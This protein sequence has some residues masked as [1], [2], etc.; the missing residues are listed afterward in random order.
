MKPLIAFTLGLLPFAALAAPAPVV[1]PPP[2][3]E[4][5]YTLISSTSISATGKN[6]PNPFNEG[7]G[8]GSFGPSGSR[9]ETVITKDSIAID[10]RT[11]N[12][13]Y[14]IDPTTKPMS[15]DITITPLRGKKSKVLGIIETVGDKLTIAYAADGAERP[16]DF[17]DAEGISHFVFQ[18]APPPP[19]LEYKIVVLKGGKEQDAEK[20]LNALAKD[21]Y[22]VMS[23]HATPTPGDPTIHFVL[24]R[25]V[26]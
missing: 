22:E 5:K 18:K 8:S 2:S 14:R 23:T 7:P 16:K 25:T 10:G 26:K 11:A 19:R 21:G 20:E 17:E 1:P 4:G 24:K 6:R 3:I 13:D 15:I 9:R 12:W